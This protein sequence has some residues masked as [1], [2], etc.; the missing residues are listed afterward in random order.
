MFLAESLDK[1]SAWQVAVK[2]AIPGL[3]AIT[4]G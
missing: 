4:D 3:K 2:Q 1:V